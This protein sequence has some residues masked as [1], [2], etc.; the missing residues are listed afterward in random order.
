M[1]RTSLATGLDIG[2]QRSAVT[3]CE[4]RLALTGLRSRQNNRGPVPAFPPRAACG[5]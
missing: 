3:I 1:G 5:G 2:L 4:P